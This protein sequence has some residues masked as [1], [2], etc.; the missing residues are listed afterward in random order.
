MGLLRHVRC[1]SMLAQSAH[2]LLLIV[3][4]IGAQR[5]PLPAPD[6]C[7]HRKGRLGFCGAAS[8]S[9]PGVDHQAVAIVHLLVPA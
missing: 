2:Q 8:L 1:D 5:D 6:L 9:E 4:P 3:T 7:R